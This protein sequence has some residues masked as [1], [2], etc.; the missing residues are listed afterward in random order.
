MGYDIFFQ[1]G[2]SPA[3]LVAALQKRPDKSCVVRWPL[4]NANSRCTPKAAHSLMNTLKH[5]HKRAL[6]DVCMQRESGLTVV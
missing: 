6:V 2:V 1:F 3:A 5:T 4:S